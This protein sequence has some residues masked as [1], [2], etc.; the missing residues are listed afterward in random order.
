MVVSIKFLLEFQRPGDREIEVG[1]C[2]PRVKESLPSI[3]VQRGFVFTRFG[4]HEDYIGIRGSSDESK[5]QGV[6][7]HPIFS[8]YSNEAKNALRTSDLSSTLSNPSN[9]FSLFS[10]TIK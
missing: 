5:K 6:L 10:I 8:F 4:R 9:I 2:W 7:L 3:G 1:R